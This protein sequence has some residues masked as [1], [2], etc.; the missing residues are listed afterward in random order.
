MF[1]PLSMRRISLKYLIEDAPRVAEILSHHKIFNPEH[2]E[3]TDENALPGHGD[4]KYCALLN[5][6]W[7]RMEKLHSKVNYP[8]LPGLGKPLA[9]ARL[10]EINDNLGELWAQCSALEE[11]CRKL[12]EEIKH[13][14]ALNRTLEIFRHL[15]LDLALLHKPHRFCALLLGTLPA[16][17]VTRLDAALRFAPLHFIRVFHRTGNTAY[18]AV[19][20]P[21]HSGINLAKFLQTADFHRLEIPPEF[22]DHPEKISAELNQRRQRS[23]R[24]LRDLQEDL[25][26]MRG[27]C[28]DDLGDYHR[29]LADAS[30][31]AELSQ[32]LRQGRAGLALSEGWV[33]AARLEALTQELTQ[34]LAGRMVISSRAPHRQEYA[35]V[36]TL[37][38]NPPWLRGFEKLVCNFGVPR[39]GE[40]DPTL[41][42]AFSSVL[43]FGMMFG[44]LGHG[45]VIA[46]VAWL[47]RQ[48]LQAFT[49]L[50][51]SAGLSSMF[52]GSLYGSIFANEHVLPALWIAPL[53]DPMLMLGVAIFW[54]VFLI[55]TST[56]LKIYNLFQA[57]R[58]PEAVFSAH[59]LAGLG[60][61]LAAL[62]L[63][64]KLF[65]GQATRADVLLAALPLALIMVWQWRAQRDAGLGERVI[66][67]MVESFETLI[68]FVS[69]TLS[70]MRVAAFGLNHAALAIAVFALANSMGVFGHGLTL[71]LGNVFILVLEGAIVAIQVL[72][73]QYYEGFVRFFSGDGRAFRP[74]AE[75]L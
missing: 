51:L 8:R 22:R 69:N 54:G 42:V 72:R 11:Q 5:S 45:A 25:Y 13:L 48:R 44:D 73:L 46:L 55:L 34:A 50:V 64:F 59:G 58:W 75:K 6:A 43:M 1:K 29:L 27:H 53:T 32:T 24:A 30:A 21:L 3:L 26:H 12:G 37:L 4:E 14:Y 19:G 47:G 60:L 31:F 2:A 61:Y 49:P 63:L 71:L 17:N 18:V 38:D 74:L 57:Q 67:V 40:I 20:G 23:E 15:D 36:P 9:R 7:A 68:S 52:F 10:A 65:Q 70:Y 39:Y 33:P 16:A 66:V 56:A 62:S 28:A 41:L 35:Q